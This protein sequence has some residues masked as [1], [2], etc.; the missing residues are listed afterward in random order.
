[1]GIVLSNLMYHSPGWL[2]EML[3][4][5]DMKENSYNMFYSVGFNNKTGAMIT[6]HKCITAG[7]ANGRASRCVDLVSMTLHVQYVSGCIITH[8]MF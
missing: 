7:I 1:M 3:T 8:V 4:D 6:L 2:A 5:R